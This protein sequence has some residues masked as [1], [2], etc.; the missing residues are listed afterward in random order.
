MSDISAVGDRIKQ[1][2]GQVFH[3]L[4][5]NAFTYE[6]R[7][8]IVIPDRTNRSLP[9]SDFEKALQLMPL[10]GPGQIQH[11]QGPSYIY[12]ILTDPRIIG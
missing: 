1:N 8:N 7:G 12:A 2:Q 10:R 6:V 11:L 4:R 3:Q 9:R 5:G